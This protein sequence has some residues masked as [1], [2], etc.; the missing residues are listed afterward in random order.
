MSPKALF[1]MSF[2]KSKSDFVIALP[3]SVIVL[4]GIDL[5][6]FYAHLTFRSYAVV[7]T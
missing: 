5:K 7:V 4:H 6:A 1:G 3:Y 2:M